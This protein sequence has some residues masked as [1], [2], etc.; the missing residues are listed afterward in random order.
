ML[1]ADLDDSARRQAIAFLE[2]SLEN[3]PAPRRKVL[4]LDSHPQPRR[5]LRLT[6]ASEPRTLKRCA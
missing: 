1:F 3:E 6:E 4:H 5:S 2:A